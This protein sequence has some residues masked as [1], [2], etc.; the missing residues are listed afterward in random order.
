MNPSLKAERPVPDSSPE[1]TLCGALAASYL[2]VRRQT[3]HLCG[4]L[5]IEDYGVQSMPDVSP[6]KWHLAHTSWFFENFL[7]RPFATDYCEFHPRFGYL[8][9]S[10]YESV[11]MFHPRPD[12]GLLSRPTVEEIYRYR[13]Y[14]DGVMT[15][16]ITTLNEDQ[17]KR[18][19][20]LLL[21]GLHHEEQHQELLLTD[22]KHIFSINPLRP[23]YRKLPET[24]KAR[25]TPLK[26]VEYAGGVVTIG[27]SGNGFAFDN[28]TPPHKVYLNDYALASRLVTNGEFLEFIEAGGYERPEYWL[29]DGWRMVKEQGWQVPLYWEN[30]N[31]RWWCM[32]LS[33]MQPVSEHAPICHVSFYEADAFARWAGKR[34]PTE[35]EWE[36]AA[37]RQ[38][39]AGN[40][41]ESDW[42]SPQPAPID[43]ALPAQLYGDVWEWTQSA[44]IPYPGYQPP[45][46]ALGEYNGK[47][48]CNQRVLRGGSCATPASHI[49]ASYRNF[50]YPHDRWQFMGLRLAEDR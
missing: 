50:F 31:G 10:Y 40:L 3:E 48:M 30:I 37:T 35:A 25:S 38:S 44:Y 47:F 4:P 6:P 14:V 21:L 28:E 7:L 23:V 19:L 13:A 11:G 46:G 8:F 43:A 9:N 24:P 18:L 1:G 49:R 5:A 39:V 12:R 20:P 32:T 36:H 27:Y 41:R 45:A 17:S 2:K 42:L 26:W 16:L 34:L 22:I 29:S 15:E 33:G